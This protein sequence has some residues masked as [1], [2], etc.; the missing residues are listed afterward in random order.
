MQP[1]Q[2]S[3]GPQWIQV[4]RFDL[5]AKPPASSP[6]RPANPP[7]PKAPPNAE[8]RQMLA[9]LLADRFQ[10]KFHRETRDCPV[11]QLQPPKAPHDF[12]LGRARR[13]RSRIR[14]RHRRR[15]HSHA[16]IG[17]PAERLS[18]PHPDIV[19]AI[20]ASMQGLGLKLEASKCPVEYNRHRPRGE[21]SG[22]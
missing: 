16:A 5:E 15:E 13:R 18:G 21:A 8:Q 2:V 3:G 1:Y 7:Y 12:P 10:L 20:F 4:D 19:S 6:S 14:Q 9:T 22:N 11:Y 17:H